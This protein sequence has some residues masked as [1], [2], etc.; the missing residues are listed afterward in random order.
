[1]EQVSVIVPSDAELYE[2][3]MMAEAQHLRIL[4]DGERTVLSPIKMPGW[5]EIGVR[6][7]QAA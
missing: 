5:Y 3:A 4:T 1:M 2:A 7:K 6:V